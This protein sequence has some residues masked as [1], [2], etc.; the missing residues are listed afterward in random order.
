MSPWTQTSFRERSEGK[1]SFTSPS[2]QAE[3]KQD[4]FQGGH[5][6][7]FAQ[8]CGEV[9]FFHRWRRHPHLL[10]VCGRRGQ[11]EASRCLSNDSDTTSDDLLGALIPLVRDAKG[12]GSWF[13]SEERHT[14]L[15]RSRLRKALH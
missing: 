15:H 4:N 14:S 6:L 10:E 12:T 13:S 3:S 7:C 2:Q 9:S 11:E 8:Y 1:H 5:A